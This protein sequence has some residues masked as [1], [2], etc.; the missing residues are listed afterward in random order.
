[1][2]ENRKMGNR[3]QNK[4]IIPLLFDM[5]GIPLLFLV[6]FLTTDGVLVQFGYGTGVSELV[7]GNITSLVY[8]ASDINIFDDGIPV[9]STIVM[10]HQVSL[11][12]GLGSAFFLD[13]FLSGYLVRK[14]VTASAIQFVEFGAR[15]ASF[16][17]WTIWITGLAILLYY[18]LEAP[19]LLENPKIWGKFFIV[20]MLTINGFMIH[21]HAIP[22]LKN[23]TGSRVL[24]RNFSEVAIKYLPIVTISVVSWAMAFLLGA[25]KEL[26]GV[27]SSG[28]IIAVYLATLLAAYMLIVLVCFVMKLGM[29]EKPQARTALPS[30]YR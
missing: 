2:L 13:M 12:I 20:V 24:D 10:L 6:I 3:K 7:V 9:R 15:I 27:V 30:G 21:N 4:S 25:Y 19:Q 26:N 29:S 18:F 16:G 14:T 23:L 17:L 8:P 1:M 5:I 28:T 11:V 22:S